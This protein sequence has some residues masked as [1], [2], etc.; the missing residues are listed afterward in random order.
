M[1]CVS[2]NLIRFDISDYFPNKASVEGYES[3]SFNKWTSY[4]FVNY[5]DGLYWENI[6]K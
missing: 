1:L 3:V 2:N 5:I 6:K 4:L